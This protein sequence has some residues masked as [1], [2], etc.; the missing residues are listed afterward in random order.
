MPTLRPRAPL[1]G[2]TQRGPQVQ[3]YHR[4]DLPAVPATEAGTFNDIPLSHA[5]ELL[6][7]VMDESRVQ[8]LKKE[9]ARLPT[10]DERAICGHELRH[11][12]E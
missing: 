12:L 2:Q 7:Q 10:D 3:P 1:G 5:Q 11:L 8:A 6:T 9:L 4:E